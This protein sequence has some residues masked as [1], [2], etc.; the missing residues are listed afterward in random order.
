MNSQNQLNKAGNESPPKPSQ[1]KK[2]RD[3]QK[4]PVAR[5]V[6]GQHGR[7]GQATRTAQVNV[8]TIDQ[9]RDRE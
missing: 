5:N 2:Q 1:Q 9:E 4:E 7:P 3:E 8:A 6:K